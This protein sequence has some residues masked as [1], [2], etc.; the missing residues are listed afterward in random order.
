MANVLLGV[1][2]G[3]F[4]LL[5]LLGLFWWFFIYDEGKEVYLITGC[6]SGKSTVQQAVKTYG[7]PLA[8]EKQLQQ[9]YNQGAN[10]CMPGWMQSSSGG[11]RAAYVKQSKASCP[12]D[13]GVVMCDPATGQCPNKMGN[14]W[15][16]K[17]GVWVYGKKPKQSDSSVKYISQVYPWDDGTSGNTPKW[18]RHGGS[19]SN[20]PSN[21]CDTMEDDESPAVMEVDE[22]ELQGLASAC[23][24]TPYGV[25]CMLSDADM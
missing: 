14:L 18:S 20:I 22:D 19:V 11:Y 16:G 17:A 10:V 25:V 24:Q 3:A 13:A 6:F 12:G 23:V 15:E 21:D 5:I 1:V 7:V 8:T 9:A 2:V 4:I